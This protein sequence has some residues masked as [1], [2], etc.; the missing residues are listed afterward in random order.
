MARSLM[1][2]SRSTRILSLLSETA[3]RPEAAMT[4][5]S[6]FIG[7]LF[8][9]DGYQVASHRLWGNTGQACK[10]CLPRAGRQ[11]MDAREEAAQPFIAGIAQH[12]LRRSGH[13]N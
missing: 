1:P 13:L 5:E 12:L 10:R 9:I 3:A 7:A 8:A 4:A 11:S 2:S 6:S